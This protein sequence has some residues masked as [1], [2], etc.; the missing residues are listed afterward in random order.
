MTVRR[1]QQN[2]TKQP[3]GQNTPDSRATNRASA[4]I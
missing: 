2:K 3:Q 1:Q 4:R